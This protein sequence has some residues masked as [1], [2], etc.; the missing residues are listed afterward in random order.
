M[1][2]S[3]GAPGMVIT[4]IEEHA[5]LD[6]SIPL[7]GPEG[8]WEMASKGDEKR[9]SDDADA[10]GGVYEVQ[11]PFMENGELL[12]TFVRR[13]DDSSKLALCGAKGAALIGDRSWSRRQVHARAAGKAQRTI[14]A[15]RQVRHCSRLPAR[16]H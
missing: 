5:F 12:P 3:M 4:S 13:I 10:G 14:Q 11:L 2:L 1:N 7:V 8:A 6:A 15:R 16:S 9:G